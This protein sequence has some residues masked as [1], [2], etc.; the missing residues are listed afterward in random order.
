MA[1]AE[2][3]RLLRGFRSPQIRPAPVSP[4]IPARRLAKLAVG[5]ALLSVAGLTMY[6][7]LL[8]R[9]SREAVMNARAVSLRAPMDGVVK[10]GANAPGAAVRAGIAIGQVEDPTADDGRAFQLQIEVGAT[11]REREAASRRLADRKSVVMGKSVD[12]GG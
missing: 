7:Q 10:A 9:V 1:V 11:E 12:L 4:P 6:Q 3:G 2:I 8:L 5:G